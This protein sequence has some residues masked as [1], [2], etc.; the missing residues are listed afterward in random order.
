MGRV[1]L[2]IADMDARFIARVRGALAGHPDISVCGSAGDG[3]R[4]LE[5]LRHLCPDV[6][7]TD[8]SLP[9]LDGIALLRETRRLR[10]PPAVIICTR[11][12]SDAIMACTCRLGASFFLCKP[13]EP[14]SL[15]ALILECRAFQT[16][17]PVEI[18]RQ[19]EEGPEQERFASSARALLQ[20][21]G[22]SPRLSG[23]AYALQAVQCCQG[24]ARLLK[25]LSSGVYAR[26]ATQSGATVPRVERALRSAIAIAYE[27]G[28]LR[29]LFPRRPT[30]RQFIEYL[31]RASNAE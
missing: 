23:Y 4:A 27:R 28:A 2:Y 9:G 22:M 11:F 26:L 7:L 29:E 3:I 21:L 31:L 25:N 5:D 10:Q 1:T 8:I 19:G 16:P 24:D 12:C 18:A 30:N 20:R 6:L 13:V 15:P 14:A 17:A